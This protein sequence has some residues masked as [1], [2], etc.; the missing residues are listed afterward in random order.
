MTYQIES[1]FQ[2]I[3]LPVSHHKSKE[4]AEAEA[5]IKRSLLIDGKPLYEHLRV[6]ETPS[7]G[8]PL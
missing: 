7:H 5:G 1:V 8:L 6:V 4:L 2:G 3:W